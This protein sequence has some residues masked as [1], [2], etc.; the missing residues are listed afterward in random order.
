MERMQEMD[1]KFNADKVEFQLEME[2]GYIKM[3]DEL[4]LQCQDL[5]KE[6]EYVNQS[7]VGQGNFNL[8]PILPPLNS[9]DFRY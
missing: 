2:K 6:K 5:C 7:K 8:F 3:S 4:F 9:Y 1:L